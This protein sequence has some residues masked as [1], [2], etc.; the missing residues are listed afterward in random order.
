[1]NETKEDMGKRLAKLA[2]L[3]LVG[4]RGMTPEEGK[5]VAADVIR[6][7]LVEEFPA[8]PRGAF[9]AAIAAGMPDDGNGFAVDFNR[10]A[11]AVLLGAT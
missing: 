3:K 9:D 1:M 2:L 5:R 4:L 7:L 11:E 10:I 6:D 8:F